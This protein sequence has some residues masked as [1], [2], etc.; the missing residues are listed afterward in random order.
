M[1]LYYSDEIVFSE[2]CKLKFKEQL[3]TSSQILN[4]NTSPIVL[5]TAPGSNKYLAPLEWSLILDYN[6]IAYATNTSSNLRWGN[7]TTFSSGVAI[8]NTVYTIANRTQLT[9]ITSNTA[10]INQPIEWFVLTGNPTAGNS[11]IF[12]RLWY[13][14]VTI[15]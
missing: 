4:G 2:N 3:I 7:G 9:N 6:T 13:L 1:A 14:E 10:I 5:V 15:N 8:N 11:N 12:I